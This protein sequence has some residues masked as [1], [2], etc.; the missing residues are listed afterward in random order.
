MEEQDRIE[1]V[2]RFLE[3]LEKQPN[4]RLK[5]GD[6]DRLEPEEAHGIINGYHCLMK[7][8]WE[9][10]GR[11]AWYVEIPKDHPWY[12]DDCDVPDSVTWNE[13]YPAPWRDFYEQGL[14]EGEWWI[15]AAS[16]DCWHNAIGFEEAFE[17]LKWLVDLVIENEVGQ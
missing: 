14:C 6:D 8:H 17:E 3:L 10:D 15:G 2:C 4:L 12:G 7:R 5:Y 16:N 9:E 1:R 13:A 11:Y